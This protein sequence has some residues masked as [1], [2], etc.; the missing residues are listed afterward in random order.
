V[1]FLHHPGEKALEYE[2][3]L[4]MGDNRY[5]TLFSEPNPRPGSEG[6]SNIV[7]VRDTR[8][9]KGQ[10][11]FLGGWIREWPDPQTAHLLV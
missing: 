3:A 4:T 9:G 7:I 6:L 2:A 1:T 10:L 8:C 5:V 11:R